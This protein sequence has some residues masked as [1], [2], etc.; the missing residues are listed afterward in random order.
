MPSFFEISPPVLEKKIFAGFLRY[1]GMAAILVMLTRL[2]IHTLI[3]QFYRCFTKNLALIGQAVSEEK[4]F[5]YYG[6][7]HV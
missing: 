4:M 6:N 1:M 2:F 3:P 5:E 7:F